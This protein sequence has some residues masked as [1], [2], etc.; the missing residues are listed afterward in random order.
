M[1]Y[2]QVCRLLAISRR[3]K[4]LRSTIKVP[5]G[6]KILGFEEPYALKFDGSERTEHDLR[7]G[8]LVSLLVKAIFLG[9]CLKQ[10]EMASIVP[11]AALITFVHDSHV[12][13]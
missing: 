13:K 9:R 6:L 4:R 1:E 5:S 11:I 12:I 10:W 3:A 8:P 7:S 2:F